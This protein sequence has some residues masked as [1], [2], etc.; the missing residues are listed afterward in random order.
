V[1]EGCS[2][3]YIR[4]ALIEPVVLNNFQNTSEV[5]MGVGGSLSKS[6]VRAILASA[7][8]SIAPVQEAAKT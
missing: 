2:C 1:G 4:Y 7:R 8:V 6:S 3:R 5:R